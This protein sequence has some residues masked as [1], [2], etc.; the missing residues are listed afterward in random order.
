MGV[1]YSNAK[2]GEIVNM[3]DFVIIPDASSDLTEE[4]RNRFDIP[5]FVS[6]IVYF[7][8]GHAEPVDLDWKNMTPEEYYNSMKYR[9]VLYKSAAPPLGEIASVYEKYLSQGKDILS[10]SISSAL[11]STY[12]DCVLVA[13]ELLQKYPE[14]KIICIDSLRY[15]TSLA[16]LVISS[17][18]KKAEGCSLEE[19]AEYTEKEKYRIHQMGTMDD[20]FFL[21]KT[22]RISNF[23]ALFG[24]MIGL[25]VL[26][27]FNEAGL[28]EV[29]GKFKGK[30]DAFTA[31]IE[32]IRQTIVNP[33]EQIIFIA[34]S[35]RAEAAKTL[36]DMVQKEFSPK[37]LIINDVGMQSGANIGPGLCAVFYKGEPAT[38]GLAKEKSIM[39]EISAKIKKK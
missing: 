24:S 36:A 28:S 20:L 12:N 35:N 15:S 8:D 31:I 37:E 32:Y 19:V 39:N 3:S 29:I 9:S 7:P 27:D 10:I 21:V 16:L 30:R 34:H 22:G 5:D 4:L 14:R 11:S 17:A 23:K 18:L 33:K 2:K 38:T 25:N 26:A 13:R 6:G 1:S